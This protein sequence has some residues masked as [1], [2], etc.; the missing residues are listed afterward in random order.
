[1]SEIR[2]NS[3]FSP[4]RAYLWPI[5]RHE[6]KKLIPMLIIF[7][8]VTF[9]YNVL[10]TLKESVLVTA[11]HSGAEVIPFAKVWG[12]FPGAVL[13]TIFYTWLSDRVSREMVCYIMCSIFLTY[14][15]IFTFFLYPIRDVIHPHSSADFLEG[16]VPV[17]FKGLIALYRYWSFTI[18]YILSE[19]WSSM[20]LTVLFWGFANQ[21]TKISEA[22]RFYGLLGVGV[23]FSG[24]FAGQISV[25]CCTY[26]PNARLFFG[27]DVWH[28][29]MIILVSLVLIIGMIALGVFRWM[30]VS[31]LKD[32]RYYDPIHVKTEGEVKGKL[33]LK[34]SIRFLLKSRYLLW[35]TLIVVLYNVVINLT[36][37]L[38]KHQVRELYPHPIDYTVYMNHIVSL[39][40]CVATLCSLFVSGSAIRKFGWT[41]T[42]LLTPAV[43]T[44]TSFAFF[45]FF[46]LDKSS[47]GFTLAAIGGVTPLAVV[48]FLGSLQ[49]ILGRAAK[50]SVF[51][52]TKEMAFVPLNP[53]SKLVGKAAIDGV[54]S[55]FGKSG[56]S[57]I[58]QALLLLFSNLTISA[59]YIALVLMGIIA[60]WVFAVKALGKQFN[61]LTAKSDNEDSPIN[62]NPVF[63]SSEPNNAILTNN[64]QTIQNA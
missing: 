16:L 2:T 52:A 51:D 20:I 17:G 42:A 34:E 27:E 33:S 61:Q 48:V 53:E 18:F 14:F 31:V 40:G 23:N 57:M 49:N 44:L 46:F 59:P 1:M 47:P 22:K 41:F 54:C 55:R 5:H 39:I 56:G 11:Q 24:I 64:Q 3:E 15:F 21:I 32:P 28:Q 10:R 37:V 4:W 43:L 29:S 12:V 8:C 58:L 38:W 35:I 13:I 45:A 25:Y 19:L 30:N 50:Y 36:E 60:V 7:F 9:D 6:L 62:S 26:S 63:T